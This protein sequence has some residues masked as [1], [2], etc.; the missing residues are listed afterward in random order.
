MPLAALLRFTTHT[1]LPRRLFV[2]LSSFARIMMN[3]DSS[4]LS[5]FFRM[6]SRS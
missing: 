2:S 5:G 4:I 3:S 1:A 6:S